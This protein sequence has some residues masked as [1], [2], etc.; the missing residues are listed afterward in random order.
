[1]RW[2]LA[3]YGGMVA[4]DYRMARYVRFRDVVWVLGE[5]RTI[6]GDG[7]NYGVAARLLNDRYRLP[8]EILL[9]MNSGQL[10]P[11]S[12]QLSLSIFIPLPCSF[13]CFKSLLIFKFFCS[14]FLSEKFVV[15]RS[16]K[17]GLLSSRVWL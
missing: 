10:L 11:Q 3:D 14:S 16:L 2:S 5:G 6:D 7:F 8:F 1:M 12:R 13:E 17:D 9:A 4:G 15:D